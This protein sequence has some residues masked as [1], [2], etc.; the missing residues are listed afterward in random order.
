MAVKF[1]P[2]QQKVIDLRD[3]NVLVSA[4]AGSGKTAVLV[5][6]IV[7]LVCDETKPVDIDRL[8]IVTFTNA[9]AAEMRERISAGISARMDE[10][11]ESEHIQRQAALLH[12][13]QISTIDSF[14]LFLLRNHF[15]EIGLDPAFRIADEGE[16]KLLKQDVMKEMLEEYFASG[17]ERFRY[18]VEFFC[19]NGSEAALEE[20]ILNLVRYADSFPWPEEWLRERKKDYAPPAGTAFSDTPCGAY[21]TGYLKLT[22]QGWIAKL[23]QGKKLCEE[24]DGPYMYGACLDAELAQAET[25][26]ACNTPDDFRT[27]LPKVVFGRLPSKADDSVSLQKRERTKKLRDAVKKSVEATYSQFFGKSEETVR[28][29]EEACLASVEMLIDLALDFSARFAEKKRHKKIVTFPDVEHFALDILLKKEDGRIVPSQVAKEYRRHF[30]EIMTDEYQDSNLVQ[31]YLLGALSGEEDGNFNRFMV[32]DVKQSIYKFRLARPELFLEKYQAYDVAGDRVRVDLSK[33]FRSRREVVDAVNDVFGRIMSTET[34]GILYDEKAAL[35]PGAE[36]PQN[37]GDEAE[38]LLIEKPSADSSLSDREAEAF[39][40]A[41]KIKQLRTDL[42]VTEKGS[43]V[44]RPLR[45]SD[46][47]ILLRTNAGWDEVFRKVLES[48]GIPVHAASKTGY[49]DA[50]EVQELLQVL[51]VLDNPTQDIPLFGM[52]KSLFGG[53]TD[54]EIALLRSN[55]KKVSLYEALKAYAQ[56]PEGGELAGKVKTFLERIAFYRKLTVYLPVRE[57]LTRIVTDFDYLNYVTAL[58]A[59]SKRRANVEMLFTRAS[60]FEKTSYFGLFHFVRYIEQLQKY[61]VDYGEGELLDENADVVRIMSIHKSKGLEFPVTFVSGMSKQFNKM[62]MRNG[63]ILDMDMGLAVDFVDPVERVR[64]KTLRKHILSCKLQ[65]DMLAEELRILYVAMTRAREKLILIGVLND[66]QNEWDLMQTNVTD[67][68]SFADFFE[69]KSYMD[70]LKPVLAGTGIAVSVIG[71]RQEQAEEAAEQVGLALKK[72]KLLEAGKYCDPEAGELLRERLAYL[73][74]FENLGGLYTKTTVSELKI[75]AMADRDEAAYHLFEEKEVQP[76]IPS[77]LRKEETVS[78]AL[79]GTAYHRVMEILDF[80]KVFGWDPEKCREALGDLR[81]YQSY[82]KEPATAQ[83]LHSFLTHATQTKRLAK[84]YSEA[85]R[86]DKVLHFLESELAYRMW[87]ADQNGTLYREQPFVLGIPANRLND[88][89]PA[90]E[91]VLIQGVIDAFWEEEDGIVLLDYKTD[92]VN[93]LSE[94]YLRYQTQLDY[95]TEALQKL[96]EKPVTQQILYSFRL[97]QY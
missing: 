73:Y 54:E 36:Y 24:P 28:R 88:A 48:Q 86:E 61:D 69:S 66:A 72:E 75:A 60:D 32:G 7:N 2:D 20:H 31:E 74:P 82:V 43:N 65:E 14:C 8:L 39:A 64:C 25:L 70:F 57:L 34:G 59:G 62:D 51:R 26:L 5:E 89:F 33:N 56:N 10:H 44:L 15:H 46:I 42:L 67:T 85:V 77:F 17:D 35:Y 29:Q 4:A 38:F 92:A 80:S 55:L 71:E 6:R 68:L 53:F 87:K 47:V 41:D 79:R 13:A 27:N 22:V 12:N 49:F 93:E 30:V 81:S 18:C 96:M 50:I 83:G 94:L 16:I 40:V 95:Y 37:Q 21:L 52:M 97:E 1:T 84:E 58:P 19:H 45:Y 78:G 76:Y 63:M 11:P 90:E 9:A 23:R 3:C 91:K